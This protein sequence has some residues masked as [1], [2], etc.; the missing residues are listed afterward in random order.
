MRK[1]DARQYIPRGWGRVDAVRPPYPHPHPQ[2][3]QVRVG[4]VRGTN[5]EGEFEELELSVKLA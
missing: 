2:C 5:A 3:G 4:V 1:I